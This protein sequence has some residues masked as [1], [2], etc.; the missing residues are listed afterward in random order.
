M[1]M[2]ARAQRVP[3]KPD[4]LLRQG[5][6]AFAR[7]DHA[8][9]ARHFL[10]VLAID[11]TRAE[12]WKCLG[13]AIRRLGQPDQARQ[14]Y[15][16]ALILRPDDAVTWF[17][18]AITLTGQRRIDAAIEA[19]GNGIR[20]DPQALEAHTNLALL[21]VLKGD[22]DTA[23]A[24]LANAVRLAPDNPRALA[25]AARVQLRRRRLPEAEALCRR[26]LA[27]DPD[28]RG[29]RL[30]LGRVL[31][32]AERLAE[33]CTVLT[34][35][36]AQ[37]PDNGE[38]WHELGVARMAL[39]QI[40]GARDALRT[41]V[42]LDPGLH[43]S[44]PALA[45]LVDFAQEPA[46]T[47]QMLA[48]ASRLEADPH[49]L[50]GPND[51]LVP[52]HFATGKALDDRGDHAGAIRR[53]IA[54]GALA[55][56][57]MAFDEAGQ[58]ALCA[59]IK[60]TFTREAI[61]G[62]GLVG[63]S[64][65]APVFIVGM[66]RS[67]STLVEQILACYPAVHAGDEARHL[68]DAIAAGAAA[69]PLLP[70]YPAMARALTPTH[71]D[72][73]TRAWRAAAMAAAPPG[74]RVTDKLLTNFFFLGLIAILFPRAKVIQTVRDPVDT[75]VSAFATLFADDL[76]HTY[77][78]GELGRYYCRYLDLMAHWRSVLPDGMLTSVRYEDLVV[79]VEG[80]ARRLVGFVGLPWDA[81]CLDFHVS[82]RAVRTASLAQVRRPLYT[83]SIARWH[84]Y[85]AAL[86]PLIAAL[87]PSVGQP[88][89][90]AAK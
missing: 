8:G 39:G 26:V 37:A 80:Q 81:A 66:A 68:P 15:E 50:T 73:I 35:L 34:G 59:A 42:R 67:G 16:R 57:Q 58:I 74:A 6:A 83:S 2:A 25:L 56:A 49:R 14:A 89:G 10:A 24:H 3:D 5:Q 77:D 65:V 85:G 1:T 82:P 55:R 12:A 61:A 30:V 63:D 40:D 11:Q 23:L 86:D 9:A 46:L 52:M 33:A 19:F 43:A 60:A 84:R 71:V 18:L 88:G 20:C 4:R 17:A 64:S 29:V 27:A 36:V 79:D 44:Y 22:Y 72:T 48:E 54:G 78:F 13:D 69:D 41:A 21:H 32:E 51:P 76:P 7:A 47:A 53:Y 90:L 62:H 31:Y 70:P 45:G 38:A 28:H 75:C 87:A